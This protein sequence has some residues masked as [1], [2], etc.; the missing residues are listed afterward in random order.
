MVDPRTAPFFS[1]ETV[2]GITNLYYKIYS[3]P[4]WNSENM[5]WNSGE[6]EAVVAKEGN[7]ISANFGS[8]SGQGI[9]NRVKMLNLYF[10]VLIVF[11]GCIK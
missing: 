1:R 6:K 2:A 10:F 11:F 8:T 7:D 4:Y 5:N 3:V 9:S